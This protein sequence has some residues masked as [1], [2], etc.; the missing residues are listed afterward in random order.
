MQH[1]VIPFGGC[2]RPYATGF[3]DQPRS[4]GFVPAT[5]LRKKRFRNGSEGVPSGPCRLNR[6]PIRAAVGLHIVLSSPSC[7]CSPILPR[8]KKNPIRHRKSHAGRLLK[9]KDT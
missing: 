3:G 5:R 2:R 4:K 7:Y 6:C 8:G 9:R 1:V